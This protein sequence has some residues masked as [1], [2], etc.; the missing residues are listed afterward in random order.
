MHIP[1]FNRDD[2][3]LDTVDTGRP[4]D[5][6]QFRAWID[7]RAVDHALA[8]IVAA[9]IARADEDAPFERQGPMGLVRFTQLPEMA[10]TYTTHKAYTT[11]DGERIPLCLAYHFTPKNACTGQEWIPSRG[12]IN[13]ETCHYLH[14]RCFPNATFAHHLNK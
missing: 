10:A 5:D 12:W 2:Y 8:H 4:G 14:D 6:N 1:P 7:E 11:G 9:V 13:C 3:H